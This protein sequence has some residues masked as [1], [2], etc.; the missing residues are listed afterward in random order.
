MLAFKHRSC[1]F[2]QQSHHCFLKATCSWF[3]VHAWQWCSDLHH[4]AKHGLF[5]TDV[6]LGF[7]VKTWVKNDQKPFCR[8]APVIHTWVVVFF[9]QRKVRLGFCYDAKH[10]NVTSAVPKLTS[11]VGETF[12][13]PKAQLSPFF[14][15]VLVD[16]KETQ[17]RTPQSDW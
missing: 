17:K 7:T 13:K 15:L 5:Y 2:G 16:I 11:L 8:K 6:S 14:S 4:K 9:P 10:L 12:K 1:C 3:L